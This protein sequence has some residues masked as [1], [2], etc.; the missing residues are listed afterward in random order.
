MAKPEDHWQAI[1]DQFT[2][3]AAPFLKK[4]G[5]ADEPVFRL[6]LEATGVTSEDTVLDV[7]GVIAP[8]RPS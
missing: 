5:H 3:Q 6:F 8:G 1:L 2:R 7:G 4:L